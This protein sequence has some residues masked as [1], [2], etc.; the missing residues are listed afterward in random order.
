MWQE[1]LKKA[2]EE[3]EKRKEL[4]RDFEYSLK[5][6]VQQEKQSIEDILCRH[7]H[8]L[9][10]AKKKYQEYKLQHKAHDVVRRL[11]YLQERLDK[12][13]QLQE[14]LLLVIRFGDAR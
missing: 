9:E 4:Q 11:G 1:R 2:R 12:T 7:K 14:Y 5:L 13:E 3:V 10:E 8:E 6:E